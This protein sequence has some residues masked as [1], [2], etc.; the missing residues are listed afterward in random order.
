MSRGV[1]RCRLDGNHRA[2]CD[3]LRA[4]G[5]QVLSL[6]AVGGGCPDVLAGWRG[7]NVLLE[8][9]DGTKPPSARELTA[10]EQDFH[11]T[12]PGQVR[13]VLSPEEAVLAVIEHA[14][15]CGVEI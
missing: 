12:W 5:M 3:A 13:T 1:Q 14:K 10:A 2:V 7:V 11:A 4:A 6:A 9:K 8:I 15:A